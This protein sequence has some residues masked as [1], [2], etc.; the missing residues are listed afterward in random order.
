MLDQRQHQNPK[1]LTKP[2]A[3][4]Q[5]VERLLRRVECHAVGLSPEMKLSLRALQ[6]LLGKGLRFC[7]LVVGHKER[8]PA[9]E[10]IGKHRVYESPRVH[11]ASRVGVKEVPQRR[12]P[13]RT[14]E[15]AVGQG[16]VG[17]VSASKDHS[18]N[19]IFQPA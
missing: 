7:N 12:A 4:M 11:R 15:H 2:E 5:Q 6:L 19:S 9:V 13:H 14:L 1:I 17:R 18:G 10:V 3:L 8:S 16:F